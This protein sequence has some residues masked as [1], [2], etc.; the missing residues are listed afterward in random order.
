MDKNIGRHAV[1]EYAVRPCFASGNV[2]RERLE[3][4]RAHQ[5]ADLLIVTNKLERVEIG[6]L[7]ALAAGAG[8]GI[9]AG[10][11]Y[12]V[13]HRKLVA[14]DTEFQARAS[15]FEARTNEFQA[16]LEKLKAKGV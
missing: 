5:K 15:E 11:T 13:L 4:S 12:A 14:Q 16:R 7:A 10:V 1:C 6:A 9:G 8:A 3:D 2:S